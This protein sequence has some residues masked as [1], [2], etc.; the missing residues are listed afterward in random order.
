[1]KNHTSMAALRL[2]L[3]DQLSHNLSSLSDMDK[4]EDV[5]LIAE[6][7]SEATYVRHHKRKIAFIFSAMRHFADALRSDGVNVRYVKF[8]D[9]DNAGSLK[10]EVACALE[11]KPGRFD[12]VVATKPGEWRLLDDMQCWEGT[13]GTPVE[14]RDDDRFI[15][16]LAEFADWAEGRKQLRMEYFYRDMRRKTDLLMKG[17]EPAGG[18][19]N[20]DQANRKSLPKS[21]SPPERIAFE[22]DEITR[23]VLSLVEARFDNHFGSLENFDYAVTHEDAEKALVHFVDDILPCFGDYQDAMAKGEAFL[24]HSL[25][26]AYLNCGLLDPL[27][28]CRRAEAAWQEERAP[29][30]AVEGFI[31][32]IIGWR[33]YVRGLYWYKMPGYA[34]TNYLE[35]NR[36]LPDFY[37][38]GETDM[39]CIREAVEHTRKHAYSHHIQ[40]LMV[41]GNFALLAGI[42]PD[43]INEWYLIVYHDAYEWV[44]LPNTHGMAIF[45][46]GGIMASKPYAASA[47]YINKMSNYC[48]G[49]AYHHKAKTG[50]K[51]CPFN[52]LYWDFLARNED[53]LRGNP[54]M[55]L[56]YKNLD[57]KDP[58]EL[59]AMSEQAERFLDEIGASRAD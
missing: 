19:W 41:T 33:E 57:K 43:E 44:E 53:K 22:P 13:F 11:E 25:L 24:W 30:N 46:D 28:V 35:A 2:V 15:A 1:L 29:L 50:E 31:R 3:G 48:S 40:R 42:H 45:A 34:K 37:W 14:L 8:D 26:S 54:R 21:A 49:C 27:D 56:T 47:N 10:A 20:Y 17:D 18:E 32:Q 7:Q 12:K 6:V 16:S 38:T 23:D 58:D 39:A 59:R 36:K 52:Y 55:G 5:V 4:Q 9:D 51:A